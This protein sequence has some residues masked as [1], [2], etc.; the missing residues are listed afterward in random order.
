MPN[1]HAVP[2]VGSGFSVDGNLR[3]R[4]L[5]IGSEISSVNQRVD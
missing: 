1:G 2:F 4:S 5:G 3:L